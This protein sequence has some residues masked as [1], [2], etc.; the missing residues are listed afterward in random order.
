MIKTYF[1][2]M[3]DLD[4]YINQT[5]GCTHSESEGHKCMHATTNKLDTYNWLEKIKPPKESIDIVEVR[6]KNTRKDF[7]LNQTGIALKTGDLIAVE[8][9][10]GHDVGIVSLAGELVYNQLRKMNVPFNA[11][12]KRVYRKAKVLDIEKWKNAIELEED[13]LVASKIIIRENNLNMKIGDIELQGD[14]TK[15][16]FYYT[17][18]ERVDFRQL[19]KIFAERF[20]L[21]IE[22][23]QI[24]ARQESGRIGGL[25]TC[26]RELCCISWKTSFTSVTTSAARLQELSPSPTRLAGQCGKLKCCLNYELDMYAEAKSAFPDTKI[27]LRT[28]EGLAVFQ[29]SD[30]FKKIMWYTVNPEKSF[31]M[32]P[33][34]IERVEKVIEMNIK[35]IFPE[36]L[37][38]DKRDVREI[39]RKKHNIKDEQD[40]IQESFQSDKNQ[41]ITKKK[42]KWKKKK[43]PTDKVVIPPKS[44]QKKRIKKVRKIKKI[45]I[46]E[47]K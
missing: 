19:I 42:R 38:Q 36:T 35:G 41:T 2:Q 45:M 25:G 21:R 22:M 11:E 24:G 39:I 20:K 28:K 6:F 23:K 27:K 37:L 16:I 14:G 15:A 10:P 34:P 7:Y 47:K 4:K 29:K 43:K 5:R 17:A 18:D 32:T 1:K 12:L 31:T 8:A 40:Q 46:N 30:V 44:T 9:S 26:G 13:L 3:K 33:V